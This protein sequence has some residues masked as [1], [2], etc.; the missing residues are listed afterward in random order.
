VQIVRRIA[1]VVAPIEIILCFVSLG[2]VQVSRV[3]ALLFSLDGPQ[4][5]AVARL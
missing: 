4:V 5:P 2:R 1:D 3:T